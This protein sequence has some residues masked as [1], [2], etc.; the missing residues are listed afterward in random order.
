MTTLPIPKTPQMPL[1]KKFSISTGIVLLLMAMV[2][3]PRILNADGSLRNVIAPK[4][5]VHGQVLLGPTC[6]VERIPPD[7]ACAP[8]P[9]KTMIKILRTA[10]GASYKKVVT[11]A[12]GRFTISLAPAT[13]ILRA[14]GASI[15][16]R[17]TDLKII[18][19]AK[20][21]QIVKIDCDT[22]IR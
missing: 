11:D 17:C 19:I 1:K 21:S 16:P 15:Y 4:G 9:Y 14:K 22:G 6:P 8:K 3:G 10:T 13:Y 12:S 7:P 5:T 2:L 18:V 20:K